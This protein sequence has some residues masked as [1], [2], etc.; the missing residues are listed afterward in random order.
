MRLRS[1]PI[2]KPVALDVDL[3]VQ[4]FRG[5]LFNRDYTM[6]IQAR[7]DNYLSIAT[8]TN[9]SEQWEDGRQICT[10]LAPREDLESMIQQTLHRQVCVCV[11]VCVC[12]DMCAFM[13]VSVQYVC[14]YVFT[15]VFMCALIYRSYLFDQVMD[16]KN[17]Y[18]CESAT[19]MK[20][21]RRVC[22][23]LIHN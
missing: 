9:Y 8:W 11:C 1:A 19:C 16:G 5:T 21:L 22:D 4:S 6:P 18:R 3:K 20:A 13:F 14:V 10:G 12:V 15:C 2:H 7:M 17:R 23:W